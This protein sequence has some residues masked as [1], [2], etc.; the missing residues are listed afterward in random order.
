VISR[1]IAKLKIMHFIQ[2]NFYQFISLAQHTAR[3]VGL[4]D[5]T[6]LSN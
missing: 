4:G 6:L 1:L 2:S 3:V 5:I